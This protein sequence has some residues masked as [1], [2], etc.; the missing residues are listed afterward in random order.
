LSAVRVVVTGVGVL[1]PLGSKPRAL[2]QA[3]VAGGSALASIPFTGFDDLG[4]ALAAPLVDFD[5]E[6]YLGAETN[7]R[8][9]DGPGRRLASAA[10]L[11][12][13]ASGW[14]AGG[15]GDDAIGLVAGTQFAGMRTIG[16]FDRRALV[17]GPQY[18]MP[19]DFANTVFNAAPGQ[20]AIRFRLTG[21]NMTVGGG[22]SAALQAIGAAVDLIRGGRARRL[23]AGGVEELSPESVRAHARAGLLAGAGNGAARPVPFDEARNGIALGDGAV[24]FALESAESAAASG[25]SIL[26]EIVGGASAWAPPGDDSEPGNGALARSVSRLLAEHRVDPAAI[27]AWSAGANGD[28]RLDREEARGVAAA[29]GTAAR[30]VA[31]TAIKSQLGESLGAAG[32]FQLAA[33]VGALGDGR[34]PGLAGLERPEPDLGFDLRAEAREVRFEYGLVTALGYDGGAGALLL[35]RWSGGSDAN[36]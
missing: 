3:L 8:L 13:A 36:R 31:V 6:R 26:A 7:L 11:A 19:L 28:P 5:A 29:L 23:L 33:L 14:T 12:L 17:A 15:R 22:A 18:V 24:L 2:H 16:E 9:F 32:G 4:G 25:R 27:G 20:T 30:E 21:P 35:R 1:S 34:L 10:A